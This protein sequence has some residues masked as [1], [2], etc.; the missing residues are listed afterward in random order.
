VKKRG[1]KYVANIK[2][3]SKLRHLGT[4]ATP[5]EAALCCARRVRARRAAAEAGEATGDG[6][7]PLTADEARAAAAAEGLELKPSSNSATGFKGVTVD[8]SKYVAK[9]WG[10]SKKHHLGTFATPE[11]AALCC[12]RHVRARRAAAEAAKARGDGPQ[13][14]LTADEARAAAAAEGLEL[15]PS[16]SS[17]TGFKGVVKSRRATHSKYVAQ[18]CREHGKRRHLGLFVTPEEAALCY[19]RHV[20]EVVRAA[21]EAG[22]ARGDGPQPPAAGLRPQLR[23][24]QRRS[25]PDGS[26]T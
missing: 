7:Q 21:A 10:S 12:A 20:R 11:E 25:A 5:E 9:I 6:P 23:A 14:P 13:P 24:H 3:N 8:G 17:A 4:F 2:E 22:E 18:V 15:E 16:S 1:S 19:A 26:P